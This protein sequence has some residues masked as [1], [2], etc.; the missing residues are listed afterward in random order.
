VIARG[1]RRGQNGAR[2]TGTVLFG[3]HTLGLLDV[4]R[5]GSSLGGAKALAIVGWLIACAA[6]VFLWQRP[7][8]E[9]FRAQR[10]FGR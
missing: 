8:S 3:L 10:P 7:S 2:T 9:F 1:C 6:V 5:A 4:L